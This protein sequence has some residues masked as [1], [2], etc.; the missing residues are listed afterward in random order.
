MELPSNL[1]NKEKNFQ[2]NH[3]EITQAEDT[4]NIQTEINTMEITKMV[5]GL[6]KENISLQMGT[7]MREILKIIK[8]MGLAN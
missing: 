5:S 7:S 1:P 2:G 3:L 8:S 6:V 4:L